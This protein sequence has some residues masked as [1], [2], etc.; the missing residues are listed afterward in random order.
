MGLEDGRSASAAASR[1][2]R[3]RN[4]SGELPAPAAPAGPSSS[5]GGAALAAGG[6]ASS[7]Y[8][9]I[10][11]KFRGLNDDA[12]RCNAEA[13]EAIG[14]LADMFDPLGPLE[15]RVA[16]SEADELEAL[17]LYRDMNHLSLAGGITCEQVIRHVESTTVVLY[18]K[19]PEADAPICVTAA[20]FSL[21][22]PSTMMLRLL[23]THPR[24]TR[25]GFARLTVHFLKELCRALGK[26][27]ILV[28]TH[29]FGESIEAWREA[30]SPVYQTSDASS[31][32]GPTSPRQGGGRGGEGERDGDAPPPRRR[33]LSRAEY[34]V[35]D[36]LGVRSHDGEVQYLIKWKGCAAAGA[37]SR[38]RSNL[39]NLHE[40]IEA[41]ERSLSD[42]R[43]LNG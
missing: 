32:S 22:P 33:R 43:A 34:E 13:R 41:F 28:Y 23:A 16:E 29:D 18:Y 9:R 4:P 21:R 40:E 17:K 42:S 19:H 25:K 2:H 5:N 27:Q 12:H 31:A 1:P 3:S 11:L 15:L 38:P 14:V 8:E 6:A 10:G 30:V 24:M 35:E 39:N 7:S 36:I 20:T 37:A 26:T